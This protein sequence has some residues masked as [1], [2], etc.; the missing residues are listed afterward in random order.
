[1]KLPR[2][3]QRRVIHV[4]GNA[5]VELVGLKLTGGNEKLGGAAYVQEGSALAMWGCVVTDNV[6]RVDYWSDPETV[7][8]RYYFRE[9]AHE[10]EGM[11]MLLE[12]DIG[13]RSEDANGNLVQTMDGCGSDTSQSA[14]AGGVYVAH[15][16]GIYNRGRLSLY[17]TTIRSNMVVGGTGG[18][19]R[20]ASASSSQS[21]WAGSA[22][23]D[24]P[25]ASLHA[26]A[27]LP[28]ANNPAQAA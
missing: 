20:L 24:R 19:L 11:H 12:E 25:Q 17:G 26:Y 28:L 18:A 23:S 14:P 22:R 1:M 4:S 3:E 27:A 8:S 15:G 7:R 5:T 6:A 2:S 16:G 21:I 9:D 13:L 10:F